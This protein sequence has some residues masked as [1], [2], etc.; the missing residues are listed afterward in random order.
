VIEMGFLT[1]LLFTSPKFLKK[2]TVLSFFGIMKDDEAHS[3]AICLS[4]IPSSHKLSTSLMMVSSWIF[5]TRKA[6]P[7]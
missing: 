7:W 6:G 2:R 1:N 4:Y 3:D 5:G